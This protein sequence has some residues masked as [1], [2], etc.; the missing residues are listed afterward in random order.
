MAIM[1]SMIL[2]HLLL[3]EAVRAAWLTWPLS[4]STE[5]VFGPSEGLGRLSRV[6][7]LLLVTAPSVS[8]Q[9]PAF[10]KSQNLLK[11]KTIPPK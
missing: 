4:K 2:F 6:A 10:S 1:R 3:P 9:I 7:T 5:V 11:M 8:S